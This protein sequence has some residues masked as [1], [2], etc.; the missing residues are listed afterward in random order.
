VHELVQRFLSKD[1]YRILSATSGR[2]GLDMA[3]RLK[4]VAITLDVLMPEMDGWTV[5]KALKADPELESIPVIMVTMVDDKNLGYAL[6][7]ANFLTK[8]IDRTR[9]L[10]ALRQHH[11][12]K[13]VCPILVVEDDAETRDVVTRMLEREGHVVRGAENGRVALELLR[14]DPLPDVILLDL[15]MP[16]MDG[17]ELV[18]NLKQNAQ[19]REIP[20][21]VMTAKD[22]SEDDHRRLRGSVQRILQKGAYT[23]ESLLQEIRD[24]VRVRVAVPPAS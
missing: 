1:G 7:A 18:M 10:G 6:G 11:C 9:L 3:R 16:E 21:V 22:L 14:Q 24:L 17:F 15:M 8:P 2:E 12:E 13:T 4:P 19:W 5:L 23:R 20:I